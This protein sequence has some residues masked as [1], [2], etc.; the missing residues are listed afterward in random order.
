MRVLVGYG[1]VETS[2]VGR[3]EEED[4][5]FVEDPEKRDV[6]EGGDQMGEAEVET[7]MAV[8]A[9]VFL[10]G[11]APASCGASVESIEVVV[12]GPLCGE[13]VGDVEDGA[14]HL[15]TNAVPVKDIGYAI[16]ECLV[17]APF[18]EAGKS[19]LRMKFPCRVSRS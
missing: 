6:L 3:E 2:A 17:K 11:D 10:R 9:T 8:N 7:D 14:L 4:Y 16:T 18:G 13:R 19:W 5:G 1:G 12:N 15:D